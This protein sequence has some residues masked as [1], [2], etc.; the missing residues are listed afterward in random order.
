[1]FLLFGLVSTNRAFVPCFIVMFNKDLDESLLFYF[2]GLLDYILV[3]WVFLQLCIFRLCLRFL[4]LICILFHLCLCIFL[5]FLLQTVRLVR[6]FMRSLDIYEQPTLILFK[7]KCTSLVLWLTGLYSP[8]CQWSL[9]HSYLLI[10]T[11]QNRVGT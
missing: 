2:Q 3:L 9:I 11:L 6:I 5:Q 7:I 8:R 1:M 10:Y 4:C